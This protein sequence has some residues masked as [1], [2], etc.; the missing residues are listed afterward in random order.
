MNRFF[1]GIG[2]FL[3]LVAVGVLSAV[4]VIAWLLRQEEVRVP[5]LLGK[6][7]VSVIEIVNQA[8]LQLKV[9]RREPS[10]TIP[11]DSIISQDPAAGTGI[12]KGRFLRITVSLGPSELF[13]PKVI[14]EQYRKADILLR[15]AGFAEPV[16]A[17]TW[18]DTV[19]RDVVI[20]QDPPAGSPLEKGGK[21]AVLVSLGKKSRVYVTPKLVGRKAEEAVRIVDRMGIQFHLLSRATG[22]RAAGGRIVT[23]QKPASGSPLFADAVVELTV[24]K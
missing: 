3:A 18:S 5:D 21:V 8:G 14:G 1:K 24:S 7:V 4:A 23:G 6:D 20:S 16:I 22:T 11:K 19:D 15:Q 13:A 2:I 17:K 10:Q 12:K 9:D